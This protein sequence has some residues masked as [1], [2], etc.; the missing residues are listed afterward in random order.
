MFWNEFAYQFAAS[1]APGCKEMMD[2]KMDNGA[3]AALVLDTRVG[4]KEF[5]V[6]R[7]A[8]VFG[9]FH[10]PIKKH[11]CTRPEATTATAAAAEEDPKKP[12][13]AKEAAKTGKKVKKG[14]KVEQ[15][16]EVEEM[17]PSEKM[18]MDTERTARARKEAAKKVVLTRLQGGEKVK[19]AAQGGKSGKGLL[20]SHDT[21]K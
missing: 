10:A 5:P 12:E 21:L 6:K 13:A 8:M 17:M 3:V 11:K 2:N 19:R 16:E 18:K 1:D 9:G 14:E 4:A 7:C 15:N 20:S